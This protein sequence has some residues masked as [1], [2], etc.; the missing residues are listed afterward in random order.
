[1]SEQL[2]ELDSAESIEVMVLFT[3]LSLNVS[4]GR[5]GRRGSSAEMPLLLSDSAN[6]KGAKKTKPT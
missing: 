3:F 5:L 4:P 2:S 6:E 1:M